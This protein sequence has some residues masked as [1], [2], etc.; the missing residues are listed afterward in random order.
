VRQFGHLPELHR[1][2]R[3]TEHKKV[4]S[5]YFSRMVVLKKYM[6]VDFKQCIGTGGV[7]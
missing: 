7:E 2:A 1:D 3:S 4:R 6:E 5:K